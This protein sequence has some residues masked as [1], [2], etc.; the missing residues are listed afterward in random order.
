MTTSTRSTRSSNGPAEYAAASSFAPDAANATDT[1]PLA[2]TKQRASLSA[3]RE[4][5]DDDEEET[6]PVYPDYSIAKSSGDSVA[7][8]D[9]SAQWEAEGERVLVAHADRNAEEEEMWDDDVTGE[10]PE[11]H[12]FLLGGRIS[13]TCRRM[14]QQGMWS[15]RMLRSDI[16]RP[17]CLR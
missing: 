1:T 11:V 15:T 5:D 7:S 4:D 12:E 16:K 6:P 10:I 2:G 13:T 9:D 3:L 8:N 17:P 14:M